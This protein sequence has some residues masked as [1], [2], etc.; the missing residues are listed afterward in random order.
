MIGYSPQ[1]AR[2]GGANPRT[3]AGRLSAGGSVIGYRELGK[4]G[5]NLA[6]KACMA[7]IVGAAGAHAGKQ[8]VAA[9]KKMFATVL[10]VVAVIA[11]AEGVS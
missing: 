5:T 2:R 4:A 8:S 6:V 10:I 9:F 3:Q 7:K 1:L 11:F